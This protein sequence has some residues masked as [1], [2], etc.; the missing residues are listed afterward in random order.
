M[1]EAQDIASADRLLIV[2]AAG[3]SI[4]RDLPNNP[5]HSTAD[6]AHHYPVLPKYGYRTSFDAM[7]LAGDESVPVG[8]KLAHTAKHFQ[9]M[10]FNFPPTPA[11]G[12]LL[13][14]ASVFKKEDVFCWTSNVDCCFERAGFDRDR[15]YTTQGEMTK[16][17]CADTRGCGH[18]W[19]CV[20]QM[21][22][23]V[24][25]SPDGI[26]KDPSLAS[27]TTCPKCGKNKT[28]PNLRGGDWF[29]HQPYVAT[30]QR[31]LDWLDDCVFKKMSV[32]VIE[33]GVGP[34]TPI[35]T[36]I[37]AATFASALAVG[38]GRATYLRVN[39]DKRMDHVRGNMPSSGV[40]FYRWHESWA[41]LEQLAAD[42]LTLRGSADGSTSSQ[43]K[44]EDQPDANTD[45]RVVSQ[46][47]ERYTET[48]MSL[49][50]PR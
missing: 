20:E 34:S 47:Q 3:L 8:I 12:W 43:A 7:G 27:H 50:T 38:G 26:L 37:P 13:E 15:I 41:R 46:W 49:R 31:L 19:D 39:P 10:S 35:V 29:N 1:Q 32:A 28:Y 24:A 33:V 5:Y 25:A 18:V 45:A 23:V 36:S 9:N 2:A 17:Q 11:Y 22:K 4:S 44:K 14:V 6:F 48:L 16:W 21:R 40:R 30:Q 42:V